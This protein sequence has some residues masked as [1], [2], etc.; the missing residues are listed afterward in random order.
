MHSKTHPPGTGTHRPCVVALIPARAGSKGIPGKNLVPLGGRPL[1]AWTVEAA[2]ACP[3]VDRVIVS[4]D[5]EEIARAAERHG[6]EAPFLRP[7][8]LA[9]DTSLMGAVQAH[10][11]AELLR[12]G[13]RPAVMAV[14][15]PSSPFRASG[16]LETLVRLNLAGHAGVTTVRRMP[17]TPLALLVGD[18]PQRFAGTPPGAAP[19]RGYGLYDGTLFDPASRGRHFHVVVDPVQLIDIDTPEDLRLAQA[20]VD[21]GLAPVH[22]AE[23]AR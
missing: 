7:A 9:G 12:G 2:L 6:A 13:Y 4:T 8:E 18:G 17:E 16:L 10:A 20:V 11:R 22:G 19:I 3:L 21:A 15:Y 23:A 14:L 5:S 1:L